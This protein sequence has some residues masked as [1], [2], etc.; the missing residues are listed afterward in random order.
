VD[1]LIQLAEAA[2]YL[3]VSKETLRN[4]DKAGKLRAVRHPI[5]NYRVYRISDLDE[6]KSILMGENSVELT[7]MGTVNKSEQPNNT[8]KQVK[9]IIYRLHSILRDN[10]GES[11]IIERFDELTKLLFLKLYVEKDNDIF[12]V[13]G[14]E[15]VQSYASRIRVAYSR[16]VE[17]IHH[18]V[19]EKFRE[20]KCSDKTIYDCGVEL[21]KISLSTQDFDIKGLAYEEVIKG[22]F[23]KSDNQQ[24]FTPPN[25]VNFMVSFMQKYLKGKICDPACGTAGFL[26]EIARR[27]LLTDKLFGFEID[28]RLYWVSNVNLLLHGSNDFEICHFDNGGTLGKN[29]DNYQDYFDAIITNPPF[30]SDFSDVEKL[31]TYEL[32]GERTSRRRGV[33]FMERCWYLLKDNG[34]LAIIIDDGVLNLPSNKDV[35]NFILDKFDI[36]SIVSLPESAFQ[37]YASVNASILFLKKSSSNEKSQNV[38]FAKAENVGRKSNGDDDFV[39]SRNGDYHLNSD[40][41]DILSQWNLVNSGEEINTTEKFFVANVFENLSDTNNRLDFQFHHPSR[42]VSQN[43]LK[44][45]TFPLVQLSEL[46]LERNETYIPSADPENLMIMYTGLANIESFNGVAYQFPT[47]TASIKSAVKRYEPG[48]IVFARMRPNLRKIAL[49]NFEEGGYVSPECTVLAVKKDTNGHHLI[50]PDL[51]ATILRSDIVFGQLLHLV[52]GVGRPRLNVTDLRKVTLP[53]VPLEMQ[54][55]LKAM[56]ESQLDLV[57]SMKAR[58]EALMEEAATLEGQSLNELIERMVDSKL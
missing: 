55:T 24:F 11:N 23:D 52:S 4:W 13:N 16:N 19:P 48:D 7:L 34:V 22:T 8:A 28:E 12:S 53:L 38:F 2:S 45:S 39:Y 17:T 44:K 49:M 10:D 1:N 35:R 9:K 54:Y 14:K 27:N 50:I 46:C 56:Y 18:Y 57:V 6:I 58:A 26:A 41:P 20:L 29:A 43:L 32:G 25:I 36:L 51:L 30:G 5:N 47:P 21:S 40:F 37:P 33:L 31:Q 15:D 3:G 42:K